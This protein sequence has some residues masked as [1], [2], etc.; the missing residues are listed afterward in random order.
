MALLLPLILVIALITL[1]LLHRGRDG[2]VRA[3]LA[4]LEAGLER[5]LAGD[6][7][8]ADLSGIS[9]NDLPQHVH[10][11]VQAG[12]GRD[13][14]QTRRALSVIREYREFRGWKV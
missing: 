13:R 7:A 14:D 4:Q 1:V 2:S 5:L 8:Q 11:A 9:L 6:E 12:C 10:D 3:R